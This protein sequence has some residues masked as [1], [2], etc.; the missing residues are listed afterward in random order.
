MAPSLIG[1]TGVILGHGFTGA[2]AGT[3]N[4]V[5]ANFKV[6][7]DTYLTATVPPK[8]DHRLR[9]CDD[10]HGR[11]D[12]QRAVPGDSLAVGQRWNPVLAVNA[13]CRGPR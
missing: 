4:G 1:Q 12:Q 3:I 13:F 11:A 5:P 2:T 7:S 8:R 9:H 10:A 6:V